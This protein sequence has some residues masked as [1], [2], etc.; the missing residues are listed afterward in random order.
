MNETLTAYTNKLRN[1]QWDSEL[2]KKFRVK[3][4]HI[5][6]NCEKPTIS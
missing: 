6:A 1:L 4:A 3:M 2:W 5:I